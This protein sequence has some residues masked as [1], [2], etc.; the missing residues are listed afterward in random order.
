MSYIHVS[1]Y[2]IDDYISIIPIIEGSTVIE[3]KYQTSD[4]LHL[5][6]YLEC[7]IVSQILEKY[8]KGIR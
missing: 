3:V 8:P 1:Q 2:V 5:T 4:I 6:F 7:M